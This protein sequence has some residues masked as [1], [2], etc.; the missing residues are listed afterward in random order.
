MKGQ[1]ITTKSP[2]E[3]LRFGA[4]LAKQLRGGDIVLFFGDLGSGKTTLIKGIAEGLNIR[5]TKISSPT[6][7]LMNI[8]QGKLPLFHFDLYRLEDVQG[9]SSIGYDEFLYD[10]GVSVIEWADRLGAF[11]PEEFLKV[12][13]RH[14]TLEERVIRLSAKGERYDKIIQRLS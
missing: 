14:K 7:V 9:I 4:K 2:D 1:F 5:R 3:T 12:D 11:T 8:Y 10:D 13:L 6:F